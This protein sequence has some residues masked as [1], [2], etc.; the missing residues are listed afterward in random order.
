MS[1]YTSQKYK[2]KYR[3]SIRW[4]RACQKQSSDTHKTPYG[5]VKLYRERKKKKKNIKASERVNVDWPDQ[6]HAS[7][8]VASAINKDEPTRRVVSRQE[9]GRWEP[10]RRS[11][12]S[13]VSPEQILAPLPPATPSGASNTSPFPHDERVPAGNR[14]GSFVI[15]T[16]SLQP[17]LVYNLRHLCLR[18]GPRSAGNACYLVTEQFMSSRSARADEFFA[19]E[20]AEVN[21]RL[22]T[23]DILLEKWSSWQDRQTSG[24][25][26]KIWEATAKINTDRNA[27]SFSRRPHSGHRFLLRAPS[28]YSTEQAPSHLATLRDTPRHWGAGNAK[29]LCAAR[30]HIL[31]TCQG[32][33]ALRSRPIN[34]TGVI[35]GSCL[36]C[37]RLSSFIK[38]K[39]LCDV[40]TSQYRNCIRLERASQKQSSD[41]HKTPYDRVKRCRERKINIRASERVN[42]GV[43]T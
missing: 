40:V 10:V 27:I 7:L 28:A 35:Y 4:E 23:S 37:P 13:R 3:N 15:V 2:S 29:V 32:V 1:F 41:T 14:F 17:P 9:S 22:I 12:L 33:S 21:E 42:V 5:R 31:F 19:C 11:C 6:G 34:A 25:S 20:P 18:P 39:H 30:P 43:F 26:E 38:K 16:N 8:K 36:T 24:S